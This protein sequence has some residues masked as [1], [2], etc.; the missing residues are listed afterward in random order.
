MSRIMMHRRAFMR[1][2]A[3]TAGAAIT[4]RAVAARGTLT[5]GEGD[6]ARFN[7]ARRFAALAQ[8]KIAYYDFGS[9]PAALFLHGF[10]VNGYQWRGALDRMAAHRRCIAP[11]FMGLGYSEPLPGQDMR[12]PAQLAMVLALLDKLG[13]G[14]VDVIANDSGCAVA[15]L[16]VARHAPRVRTLLLTNGDTEPDCPPPALLGV[17]EAA[18]AGT[19]ADSFRP[20]LDAKDLCRQPGKLGGDTFTFPE[21]LRDDTIDMYLAPLAANPIR[22]NL[23]G[24]SFEGNPLAGVSAA[25]HQIPLPV[26]IVWGM[27]DTIFRPE[28]ADYLD[29]LFPGSRGVRRVAAARLFFPEEFPDLIAQELRALWGVR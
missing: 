23:L 5:G 4:G 15:Q 14:Q 27:G 29:K 8:G 13:I 17:I 19:F 7:A 6:F 21:R 1:T 12:A 24:Q 26:R 22:S 2:A 3:L 11:D 18:K 10:P 25:L 20:C 28:M 16:L 9:G